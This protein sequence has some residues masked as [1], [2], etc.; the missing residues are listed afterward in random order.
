MTSS[1]VLAHHQ[2]DLS[3]KLNGHN[4]KKS[5]FRII[6][7]WYHSDKSRK[8]QTGSDRRSR[9][10]QKL[11]HH[12]HLQPGRDLHGL[13]EPREIAVADAPVR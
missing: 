13:S 2:H 5:L 10:R 11:S 7:I 8:V 3:L 1:G 9:R 12:L 4:L 6:V